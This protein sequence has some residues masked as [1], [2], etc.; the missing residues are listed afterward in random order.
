MVIVFAPLPNLPFAC[1]YIPKNAKRARLE[2]IDGV[3]FE[4]RPLAEACAGLANPLAR[5]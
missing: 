3:A 4:A 2:S 1:R 5:L